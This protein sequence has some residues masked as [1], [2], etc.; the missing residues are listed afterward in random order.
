MRMRWLSIL[1]RAVSMTSLRSFD[2]NREAARRRLPHFLF[3]FIDGGSFSEASLRANRTALD[4]VELE[5]RVMRDV[6]LVDTTVQLFGETMRLPVGLGPVG[7]AGLCARR[8]ELAAARAAAACGV[9]FCLSTVSL[10]SIQEVGPVTADPFW[11]Q[12]YMVKDRAFMADLLKIASDHCSAL[13]FTVDMPVGGIRFRDFRSGMSGASGLAGKMRRAVQAAVRPGWAWDVGLRGQ[14]HTLG[15]LAPVI[16]ARGGTEDFA[17]W[18]MRNFDPSVTWDDLAFV[19]QLWRGPM[20]LKGIMN[21]QDA[22]A[23][24]DVGADGVVVSNHGGRQMDAVAGTAAVLQEVAQA[25][26][27]RLA[28]LADGGVRSGIDV[29]RMLALG[30]DFVLLGRAWAFALAASGE[31]GVVAMIETM[32]RELKAGMAMT[33]ATSIAQARAALRHSLDRSK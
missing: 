28:I 14:P 26:S 13:V 4:Q 1:G 5:Q 22:V 10:C 27:G 17:G 31:E 3:E 25:V 21:A 9:P 24:A 30:A 19:R 18:I 2:D 32:A 11:F 16:G 8:G 23:A 12:L 33:G 15:N 20:I 29:L 7:M 6:S